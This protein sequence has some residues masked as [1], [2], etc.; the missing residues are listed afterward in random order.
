MASLSD[1]CS[2]LE[3]IQQHLLDDFAFMENYCPVSS[4]SESQISRT[5]SSSSSV[6]S[7]LTTESSIFKPNFSLENSTNDYDFSEFETKPVKH[8]NFSE[9]KPSL[10]I[11]IPHVKKLERDSTVKVVEKKVEDSGERKRYR[12]VRQRPW[13]KF[14]AEIRDPNRKGTRVWLG[15]FETAVEAAKAYDR[16]AFKLRGSKAIVNFPLEIT[17]SN[18]PLPE[19]TERKRVIEEESLERKTKVVK[20]E[21]VENDKIGASPAVPLTPSSWTAV[22]D[23]GD[24][25]GIFDV[26]PLSP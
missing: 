13:G 8:T 1:D 18:P 12:G 23:S 14:A 26:P 25:K 2:T 9:R 10:N 19:N 16:A 21:E 20:R 17:N 15:T 5:S 22:W 11:H 4:F 24:M 6:I 3:I 7:D